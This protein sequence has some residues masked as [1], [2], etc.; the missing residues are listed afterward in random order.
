MADTLRGR[1]ALVTG[2]GRNLGRS[3]LLQLA[4]A[5]ADVVVNVRSSREEGQA[6]ADDARKYG[7]RVELEVCDV[8]DRAAVDG[9]FESI[10]A[11]FGRTPDILVNNAALRRHE[12]FLD[13][14]ARSWAE[15]LDASLG[16]TFQCS[17]LAAPGMVAGGWGR[18]VNI[19][20]QAAFAG[21]DDMAHVVAAKAG[22]HGLTRALARELGPSGIT[23]NAVSPGPIRTA[24][25]DGAFPDVSGRA[26]SI[27][28]RRVPSA[29]DIATTCV[30]L[31]L[32]PGCV[33]GQVIQVNGGD[34][35]F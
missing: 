35:L 8:A 22:V 6:V 3:V 16:A 32:E 17:Q 23:V 7:T 20:G 2:S 26:A 1:L 14:S 5:G 11:S 13:I 18:I 25:A 33:T 34:H 29:D 24:D 21:S 4:E 31:V 19:G 30:Y 9:M 28:I 15:V 12:K 27:P 10:R